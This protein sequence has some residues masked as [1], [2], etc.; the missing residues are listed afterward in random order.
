MSKNKP[1]LASEIYKEADPKKLTEKA[2]E[3]LFFQMYTIS[4]YLYKN[5][6]LDAVKNYDI[7]NQDCYFD[8]KIS[9]LYKMIEGVI[10]KLPKSM[11]IK[12]GLKMFI[13]ELEFL[14][15]LSNISILENCK[16]KAIFEVIKCSFR[17]EFNS[18]AKKSNQLELIDVCC[19]WCF[20]SAKLSEK[21]DLKYNIELTKKG[22]L[23]Y[24]E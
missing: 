13:E 5:Y 6:G 3:F 1:M 19:N 4:A 10:K 21:Y 23:N 17:K 22:C 12:E 8:I 15:P 2:R 18:L 11:K 7:F 14:E 16:E 20:E 9:G 24:L